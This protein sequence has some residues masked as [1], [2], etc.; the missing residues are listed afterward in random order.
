M[1]M[2]SIFTM[3]MAAAICPAAH[4]GN[5]TTRDTIITMRVNTDDSL[6]NISSDTLAL[7][8]TTDSKECWAVKT[9]LL[10]DAMLAPNVEVEFPIDYK[11]EFGIRI[12]S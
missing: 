3:F 9:N 5:T 11:P 12:E 6:Y 4:A 7:T 1:K 8:D 10:W 2:V